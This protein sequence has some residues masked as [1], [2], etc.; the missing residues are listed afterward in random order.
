[1]ICFAARVIKNGK[2][3]GIAPEVDSQARLQLD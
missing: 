1:M 3:P 2:F